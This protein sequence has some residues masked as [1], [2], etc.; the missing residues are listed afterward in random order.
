MVAAMDLFTT[1][2]NT[3][4]DTSIYDQITR[5]DRSASY[6]SLVA[7]ANAQDISFYT[8]DATGLELQGMVTAE[9][10]GTAAPISTSRASL[11]DAIRFMAEE[12]GGL[13]VVNTND[14]D[15]GLDRVARD[16]TTFYS[17]GY[18]IMPTGIDTV[19]TIDVELPGHPDYTIRCRRQ[20]VERSLETRIRDRVLTGLVL[21]FDDDPIGLEARLGEES[22]ATEDRWTVPLSVSFPVENIALIPE[23]DDYVGRLVLYMAA[24]DERGRQ[25]EVIRQ[26]HDLRIAGSDYAHV[27]DQRLQ[28]DTTMLMEAG[29][30][31]L[32]IGVMDAVT[33]QAGYA[34][35]A[36]HVGDE[37]N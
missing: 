21:P 8:I 20:F 18:T 32:V 34:D 28:V 22:L 4:G 35:A 30:Y 13:S 23:D 17:L 29:T 6:A 7:A 33:R 37:R 5:Y 19:H 26:E 3:F 12:T 9:Q 16:L 11:T 25:T 27:A 1:F 31:R 15:A 24:R 14:F 2:V 10:H 36:L